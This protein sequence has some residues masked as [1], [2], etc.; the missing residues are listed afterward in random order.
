LTSQVGGNVHEKGVVNITSSS[1]YD[2]SYGC[3]NVAD[4]GSDN[5]WNSQNIADSW[6]C[7]EF[8]R[9]SVSLK[10]YTLKS[11]NGSQGSHHPREWVVEGSKD[12][13][14][15]DNLGSQN[16]E[17]LNGP[18]IVKTFNCSSAKSSEFFRFVRLR[19]TGRNCLS[20]REY[21]YFVLQAVEFFGTLQNCA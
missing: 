8:K 21:H 11:Y 19:Q 4:H 18:S 20:S 2:S 1:D 14:T 15:W 10:N 13:S 5:I 17:E 9:H 16:T 12:G 3:W 7:F 6:I